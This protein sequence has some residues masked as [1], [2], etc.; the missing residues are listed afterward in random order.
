M[1][2]FNYI[3]KKID[4]EIQSGKKHKKRIWNAIGHKTLGKTTSSN[5]GCMFDKW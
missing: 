5:A 1:V 4:K 2:R 3:D